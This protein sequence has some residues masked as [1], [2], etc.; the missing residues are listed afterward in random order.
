MVKQQV[1]HDKTEPVDLRTDLRKYWLS[2]HS[3]SLSCCVSNPISIFTTKNQPASSP[4]ILL[5]LH[6]S[7]HT[8]NCMVLKHSMVVNVFLTAMSNR[9]SLASTLTSSLNVLFPWIPSLYP[10][11]ASVPLWLPCLTLLHGLSSDHPI[12]IGLALPL[13]TLDPL[14]RQAT[15]I[16]PSLY[17]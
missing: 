12:N 17:L 4:P 6:F 1:K 8:H 5:S 11:V 9:S 16:M 14:S 10:A 7:F 15:L 2:L 13:F 3:T